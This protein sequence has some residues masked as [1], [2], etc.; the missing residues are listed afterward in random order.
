[1]LAVENL[2]VRFGGVV[3]VNDVSF[4][5]DA[6]AVT[7]LIGPNGAGKTTT[8]NVI[9][10]LQRAVS[11]RVTLG[12]S[13]ITT[14]SPQRRAKLGMA[15]TFQRLELFG[16]LTVLENI[17][18]AAETAGHRRSAKA[19]ATEILD[20]VGLTP[21]AHRGA[22]DLPTGTARL[23]EVGRALAGR[24]KVL[25]LDEPGAGLSE[26]EGLAL[27]GLLRD[28][29]TEGLAVLLVEHDMDLVMRVCDTIVVLDTGQLLTTGTP[30]QVATHPAVQEAYLG[31]AVTATP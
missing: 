12:G 10:G 16:S 11:G 21:W 4:G 28:L 3:A 20:R 6:G 15:R 30:A 8:F 29:A 23:L 19:L 1:M 22:D 27:G 18:T 7:G 2:T 26:A 31:S 17:Q 9:S 14:A 5:A 13:D 25:L 24:P